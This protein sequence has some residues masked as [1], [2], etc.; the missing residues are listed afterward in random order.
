MR[1][2]SKLKVLTLIVMIVLIICSARTT[3]AA[4]QIQSIQTTNGSTATNNNMNGITTPGAPTNN[5]A[6]P[7][8]NAITAPTNNIATP[9]RVPNTVTNTAIPQTGAESTTMLFVLIGFATISTIYTYLK[10]KKYNI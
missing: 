7:T 2:N 8:N 10:I 9:N 6:Q 1:N 5:V 3:F 4:S